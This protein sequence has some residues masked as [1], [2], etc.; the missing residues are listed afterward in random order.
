MVP[1]Y[2]YCSFC[3]LGFL[4]LL[5]FPCMEEEEVISFVLVMMETISFLYCVHIVIVRSLLLFSYPIVKRGFVS[6]FMCCNMSSNYVVVMV[7]P[8]PCVHS[9]EVDV[10]K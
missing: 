7:N 8:P 4:E 6:H 2:C 3:A 10:K 5:N 9:C 1:Y